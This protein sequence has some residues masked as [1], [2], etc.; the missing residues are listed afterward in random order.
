MMSTSNLDRS[1]EHSPPAARLWRQDGF[2]ADEWTRV[3]A[4]SEAPAHTRVILPVEAF[5]QIDAAARADG[6]HRIGVHLVAGEAIDT[7]VPHLADLDLVSL[8]F[9]AFNDGRSYS[10]AQLLRTRHGYE[11][12]VRA[13]GDVLIDQI[14]LMIRT[15]FDEFEITHPTALRRLQEGRI[16]GTAYAYQPAARSS[17]D[18]RSYSWR[19]FSA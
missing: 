12:I 16:G 8:A 14:P 19:R 18:A 10:K 15:G 4:L 1:T 17:A 7:I 5:L 9:P 6:K 2:V 3:D 13:T 11:G